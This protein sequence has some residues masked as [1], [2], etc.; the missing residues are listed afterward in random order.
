[1]LA[2]RKKNLL[3]SPHPTSREGKPDGVFFEGS[4]KPSVD[5]IVSKPS[6]VFTG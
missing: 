6:P 2:P 1:M 5:Y 4:T 3:H